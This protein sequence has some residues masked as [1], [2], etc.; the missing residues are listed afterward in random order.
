MNS[1]GRFVFL[2][3]VQISRNM[4]FGRLQPLKLLQFEKTKTVKTYF[5]TISSVTQYITM[6]A[7]LSDSYAVLLV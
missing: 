5:R 2:G 3:K 1:L 4:N 6:S 7:W